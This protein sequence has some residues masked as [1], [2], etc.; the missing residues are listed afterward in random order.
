MYAHSIFMVPKSKPPLLPQSKQRKPQKICLPLEP[1]D[2][3]KKIGTGKSKALADAVVEGRFFVW[4][5]SSNEK[6]RTDMK[7]ENACKKQEIA[8]MKQEIADMKQEIVDMKLEKGGMKLEI[9]MLTFGLQHFAAT[10]MTTF[11]STLVFQVTL[12]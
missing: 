11:D 8:D 7:L 6:E 1:P 10:V 3:R 2:K 5:D 12:L 4:T 9:N